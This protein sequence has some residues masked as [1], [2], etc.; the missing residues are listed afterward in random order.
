[1]KLIILNGPRDTGKD[2]AADYL[3][4]RYGYTKLEMKSAL[5]SL[6]HQIASLTCADPVAFCNALEFDRDLKDTK[7][8]PEFGNRTW[9]GFIIWLSES[10]CKP[11]FGQDVFALA[12]VKAMRDS[13]AD[14]IVFSDGGFQVEV[15]AL[16][17]ELDNDNY[18]GNRPFK[19]QIIH[20]S[21][22]GRPFDSVRKDSRGYV[23]HPAA[24]GEYPLHNDA[25][26]VQLKC[27]LD[28]L[29]KEFEC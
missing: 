19:F 14:K 11:I 3:V 5:R 6:A 21:R 27:E 22:E 15:D 25:G 2:T 12:A 7:R 26:I 4:E 17:Y 9:P 28:V 24:E 18:E 1:M 10:V 13:G 29:M 16:Y 8:V 20:M 23:G